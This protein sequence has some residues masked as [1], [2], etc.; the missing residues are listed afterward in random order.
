MQDGQGLPGSSRRSVDVAPSADGRHVYAVTSCYVLPFRREPDG[1]LALLDGEGVGDCGLVAPG[2]RVVAPADGEGV[3]LLVNGGTESGIESHLR[4]AASGRLAPVDLETEKLGVATALAVSRDGTRVYATS[5]SRDGLVVYT[6]NAATGQLG[7]LQELREGDAGVDGLVAPRAVAVSPDDRDVYVAASR[8]DDAGRRGTIVRLRRGPEGTL[9]YGEALETGPL[10]GGDALVEL[11]VSPDGAELLGLDGGALV[12][13]A[14][15]VL[16]H[17][18][19]PEDGGLAFLE[20][21]SLRVPG[22]FDGSASWLALRP[23]GER[24]Y[25]GGLTLPVEEIVLAVER[26]TEGAL[27][28]L[29]GIGTVGIPTRGAVSP[30]GRFVYTSGAAGVRVLAPEADAAGAALAALLGLALSRRARRGRGRARASARAR[31]RGPPTWPGPRGRRPAPPTSRP[32]A[33]RGA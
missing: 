15:A 29:A 25:L 17:A 19:D 32:A 20:R 28:P 6:R 5:A 24:L 27:T 26:S 4:D 14:A 18:R 11:L 8:E 10:G 31:R 16:R 33:G 21:T 23:D 2:Q 30:D 22:L 9:A 7:F 12:G 13:E 3:L 1:R